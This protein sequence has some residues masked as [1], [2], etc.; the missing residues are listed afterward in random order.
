MRGDWAGHVMANAAKP[1]GSRLTIRALDPGSYFPIFDPN[2]VDRVIGC[3]IVELIGEGDETLVK[4]LTYRKTE[5]GRISSEI[6]M[7]KLDEWG[8][9]D[10]KPETVVQEL[11]ERAAR[12]TALPAYYVKNFLEPHNTSVSS[13]MRGL[14]RVIGALNQSISD[15]DLTLAMDGLRMYATNATAVD[16]DGN[17][18]EWDI[19]PAKVMEL[20]GTRQEVMCDRITCGGASMSL[21]VA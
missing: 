15:E 4:R 21:Q 11:I 9:P 5:T 12:L 20:K 6:G 13:E 16:E 2:D 10:V 1:Q 14:E 18:T 17:E 7:F 19:G 8:E 3:H